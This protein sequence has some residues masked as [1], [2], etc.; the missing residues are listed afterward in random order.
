[1]DTTVSQ[2]W[3]FLLQLRAHTPTVAIQVMSLEAAFVLWELIVQQGQLRPRIVWLGHIIIC[4]VDE[5]VLVVLWVIIVH[6][7]LQHTQISRAQPAT[8][9]LPI[10]R[11]QRNILVPWVPFPIRQIIKLCLIVSQHHLVTM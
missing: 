2:A 11:H 5:L 1:M 6:Q 8:I 10:Q 9:V 4:R 7:I 3:W